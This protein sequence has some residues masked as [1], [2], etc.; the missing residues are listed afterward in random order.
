MPLNA[1]ICIGQ[2]NVLF[3]TFDTLRY[4]VATTA[5]NEG[6]TPFL[7]ALLPD[8]QWEKRHTPATFTY[9][10]HHAFFAGYLPTPIPRSNDYQRLFACDFID[11]STTGPN[12]WTCIESTWVAGLQAAGYH[13]ICIGGVGFFNLQNALGSTLPELFSE[14]HWS[15]ELGVANPSS[16]E[17]QITLAIERLQAQA[18]NQ[19]I[20]LFINISAMHQPNYFYLPGEDQDTLQSQQAAL[21]YVDAQLP[22]LFN[23]LQNHGETLCILTSDHGTTYGEDGVVGHGIAHSNIWN[24]PYSEFVLPCHQDTL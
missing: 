7:H 19:R 9:A 4:D 21:A 15:P 2:C 22:R 6:A 23:E 10:A 17:H 1:R 13:T 12:T 3:I 20:L 24:V 16:T 11:S 18:K 5:L 14:R 8:Q